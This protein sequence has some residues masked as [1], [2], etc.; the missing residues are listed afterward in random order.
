[1]KQHVKKAHKALQILN[2]LKYL[3]ALSFSQ[4]CV[5]FLKILSKILI[6]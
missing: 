5:L 3:M 2:T 6:N 1:M 4:L